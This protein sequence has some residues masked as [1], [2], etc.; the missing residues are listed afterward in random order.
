MNTNKLLH[1][2]VLTGIL[3]L[4]TFFVFSGTSLACIDGAANL[5]QKQR[6]QYL[7]KHKWLTVSRDNKT[8]KLTNGRQFHCKT[9]PARNLTLKSRSKAGISIP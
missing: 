7:K 2:H 5:P 8:L 4:I 1:S 3:M 9:R 6:I